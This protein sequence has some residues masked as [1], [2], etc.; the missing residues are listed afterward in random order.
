MAGSAGSDGMGSRL[1]ALLGAFLAAGISL[2]SGAAAQAPNPCTP[3]PGDTGFAEVSVNLNAGTFD[4][5][6]PFDVPVRICGTV[7]AGSTDI[8]LQYAVS[9]AANLSVDA[10]CNLLAPAGVQWLPAVPISGRLDG[11]TFRVILPPLDADRYYSFCFRRRAQI[12][13]DVAAAFKPKAREVLDQGLAQV[14]SGDLSAEQSLKL[15]TDLYHRLLDAAGADVAVVKGTVFDTTS[16]N[17]ELRGTGKFH[18]LIQ[19]VLDPQRRRDRIVE[20]DSRTGIPSLSEQQLAFQQA[21]KAVPDSAALARLVTQ[22]ETAAQ[23]QGGLRQMLAGR[24]LTAALALARADDEHLFLT[25]FG[26]E[27][28]APPPNLEDPDQAAALA[29]SYA[30]S[31][32]ALTALAGLVRKAIDTPPAIA[33]EAPA[34][35]DDARALRELIDPAKGALP[36][37]ANLAFALSGL[38]ENLQTALVER[39]AAL[40]QLADRVK[41][42]ASGVEAVDGSTTGN[43]ATSQTN[44]ISADAGLVFAPELKTGVTYVGMNFY[45]RP[46]NKDAN[47]SQLGNFRQ[48]F[49]RRFS[50]TLGLT[51]QS[52]A[53]GDSGAAQ[54][55]KDLFG[56]QSLILGGGLR[57]TNSFRFSAGAVVFR[58]KDRNPLVSNYSLTTTYYLSLSFDLNVAKAFQG[59]LGGLF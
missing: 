7:P 2:A 52:L 17:D 4:R 44:Y 39:S 55:R 54:T 29:N 45:W 37:A 31:S 24:D 23:T 14:T 9:K 34:S 58:K 30:A 21:L 5:I 25:A 10:N 13:A 19:G 43:L 40:D 48:T 56:S 22:I 6:L 38:A 59:G 32:Q 49:T 36:R 46:V 28:G 15:R 1:Y 41:I 50:N 35:P 47:L 11:T 8:S 16:G 57:I 26:R 20:G 33:L 42:E 12:P 18:S 3:P 53:D 27:P 51:V